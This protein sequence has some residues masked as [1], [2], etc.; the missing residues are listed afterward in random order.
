MSAATVH[1]EP[2]AIEAARAYLAGQNPPENNGRHEPGGIS[3][4]VLELANARP[5]TLTAE[6]LAAA[7]IPDDALGPVERALDQV[8]AVIGAEIE[9]PDFYANEVRLLQRRLLSELLALWDSQTTEAATDT[10]K[11][12]TNALEAFAVAKLESAME[13]SGYRLPAGYRW[14]VCVEAAGPTLDEPAAG[15]IANN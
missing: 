1:Q 4:D 11:A 3:E 13:L 8:A 15:P 6:Y 5:V 12:D 2:E 10:D 7:T 9:G 14:K